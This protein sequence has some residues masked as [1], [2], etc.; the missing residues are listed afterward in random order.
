M[1]SFCCVHPDFLCEIVLAYFFRLS[2][3]SC[4]FSDVLHDFFHVG[5]SLY[6]HMYSLLLLMKKK[7]IL[8]DSPLTI[9]LS[10][11]MTC[12]A[13]LNSLVVH[14]KLDIM[15]LDIKNYWL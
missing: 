6:V 11:P 12:L 13:F 15:N 10:T 3:R 9:K 7:I 1:S 5:S 8:C 2:N 4:R 14:S